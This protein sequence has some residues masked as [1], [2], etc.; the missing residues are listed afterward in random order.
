MLNSADDLERRARD[1]AEPTRV[2]VGIASDL[3]AWTTRLLARLT[4]A[5]FDIDPEVAGSVALV[6]RLH[7]GLLDVAVV[8]HPGVIDGLTP[9]DVRL[10][11]TRLRVAPPDQTVS[12]AACPLPL[13][14]PP[15]H[16]QPPAHDQLIDAL[17]RAGHSG[18]V[19]ECDQPVQ[20]DA[21][22]AA[23]RAAELTLD[24]QGPELKHLPLRVRV[25]MPHG[26]AGREGVECVRVASLLD[27]A[28]V[29]SDG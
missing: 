1:L 8:R 2:R 18:E 26:R 19:I 28:L 16:H 14:V 4:R 27:A 24:L 13:V 7:D 11:Q 22:V 15:R 29:D 6:D 17:R 25:V 21:L 20:R 9:L 12:L 5:G 23:G 3:G 10:V